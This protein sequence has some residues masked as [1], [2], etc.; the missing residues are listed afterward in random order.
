M[1]WYALRA[2]ARTRPNSRRR[3]SSC[4]RSRRR[5]PIAE[6]LSVAHEGVASCLFR[7]RERLDEAVDHADLAA[8]L[9][10]ELG[11][12]GLAAEALG[13]K[14]LPEALLGRES[15]SDTVVRALELQEAAEDRRVLAQPLWMASVYWWWSDAHERARD[16]NRASLQ[17]ARELGDESS[18]PY[19]LILLG[20]VE[21]TIGDYEAA[22][23]DALEGQ[24]LA[25]AIRA[26]DAAR[27][28][29]RGRESRPRRVRAPRGRPLGGGAGARARPGDGRASSRAHR[30]LGARSS[31]ALSRASA[32]PP[33]TISSPRSPSRVGSDSASPVR[34][35]S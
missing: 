9:A 25:R 15:A 7:M 23:R 30:A 33:R 1:R 13:S 27:L 31:R 32:A 2:Y 28:Q 22:L 20:F 14:L 10:L 6:T 12:R 29:P 18:A 16:T 21:A 5:A 8:Q 26:A 24:E 35:G 4:R 17:R 19:V 34:R 11:E 3:S